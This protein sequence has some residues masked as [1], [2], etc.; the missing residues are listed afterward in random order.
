[1]KKHARCAPSASSRWL[2]C[3]S[4]VKISEN[5]SDTSSFAAE[6]GSMCHALAEKCFA[7]K[8][9]P[10]DFL[11]QS[12]NGFTIGFDIVDTVLVYVEFLYS[13]ER[14]PDYKIISIEEQVYIPA[15]QDYATPDCIGFDSVRRVL[16]VVDAKFGFIAVSPVNN[17]QLM[18]YALGALKQYSHIY[19]I[20]TVQLTIVQ[21]ANRK[22][23]NS[24]QVTLERLKTF[25][26]EAISAVERSKMDTFFETGRHCR[27]CPA[28]LVCPAVQNVVNRVLTSDFLAG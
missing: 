4:S 19:D 15:I 23:V 24:W 13:L 8:K 20:E 18:L 28:I 7:E 12:F 1:M 2:K 10:I 11:G 27:Y 5:I 9:Y 26:A 16:E 25:E 3:P 6:R 14:R 17:S 21:P 22:P